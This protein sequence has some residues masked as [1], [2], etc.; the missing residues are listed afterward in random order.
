[1]AKKESLHLKNYLEIIGNP[2]KPN[3]CIKRHSPR[4]IIIIGFYEGLLKPPANDLKPICK[5]V[6]VSFNCT[7]FSRLN[8]GPQLNTALKLPILK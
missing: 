4:V 2:N 8:T 6:S 7:V 3:I 5:Q 1:M